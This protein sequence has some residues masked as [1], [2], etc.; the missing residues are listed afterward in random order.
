MKRLLHCAGFI[1]Q[2]S[3][4]GLPLQL[5]QY[6][7]ALAFEQGAHAF[8][9]TC[10]RVE[11]G[12]AREFLR[13]VH[14]SQYVLTIRNVYV[15]ALHPMPCRTAGWL[16]VP[17]DAAWEAAAPDAVSPCPVASVPQRDRSGGA[18][19][20]ANGH[21]PAG[22]HEAEPSCDARGGAK[23]GRLG[24]RHD[25]RAVI[26]S[27]ERFQLPTQVTSVTPCPPLLALSRHWAQR[28]GYH[29]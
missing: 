25:W 2:N 24:G 9:S 10:M 20:S 7:A 19:E 11:T 21:E 26:M 1:Q 28:V 5:S 16:G 22:G 6:E 17:K 8:P 18:G 3:E 13:C 15:Y 27:G 14:I 4:L 29:G 23:G 12:A